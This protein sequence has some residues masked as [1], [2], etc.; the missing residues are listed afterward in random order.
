MERKG[1]SSLLHFI[2][3]QQENR[4]KTVHPNLQFLG[5]LPEIRHL[6]GKEKVNQAKLFVFF[7]LKR[8]DTNRMFIFVS[9]Q[10]VSDIGD[11]RATLGGN[12]KA[13]LSSVHES[14]LLWTILFSLTLFISPHSLWLG[15]GDS[16]NQCGASVQNQFLGYELPCPGDGMRVIH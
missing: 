10:R 14:L 11:P 5:L 3:L 4:P 2:H 7:F 16:S 8:A 9:L 13:L 6:R 1:K 15:V 12:I